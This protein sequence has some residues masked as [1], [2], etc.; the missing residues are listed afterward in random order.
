MAAIGILTTMTG[1]PG[2]VLAALILALGG[3]SAWDRAL[4]RGTRSPKAIEILSSGGALVRLQSG[5][6]AALEAAHGA[7][8][9]RFW[10]SLQT[11]LPARRSLLVVSGMLGEEAFRQLRLWALWGRVPG[12]A[13][14]Q[15][16]A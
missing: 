6:S 16:P 13:P 7:G 8:V 14:G 9:T 12:V 3:F 11:A 5:E 1:W 10:V 4:L 15:R 2:Q